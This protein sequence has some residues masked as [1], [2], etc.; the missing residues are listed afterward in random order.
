MAD[1]I[2]TQLRNAIVAALTGLATTGARVYKNRPGIRVLQAS[3]L[4]AL[5]VYSG[6]E[7]VNDA[8][9]D[10]NLLERDMQFHVDL[11]VKGT[12]GV[13]D[14]L[15]QIRKEVEIALAPG[16]VIGT[17]T[18]IIDYSGMSDPDLDADDQ[19]VIGATLQIACKVY[20]QFDVPDQLV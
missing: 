14:V 4:P 3:E 12:D 6:G 15:D 16:V 18:V 1:H 2:A 8:A 11:R 7:D 10:G 20:T 17:R 13:D 9:V 5:M 19:T